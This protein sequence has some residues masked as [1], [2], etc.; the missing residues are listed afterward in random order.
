MRHRVLGRSGIRV[1]ELCLGTMTFG[2]E[3]G[4]GA[5]E[6][7]CREI[8]GAF[9]EAGG[10]F[11]DTANLYTQGSSE[12]IVGRLIAEER[13]C[14]VLATKFTLPTDGNDPNSG[15]S[16]RKSLRQSLEASLR[17]LAVDYVD[18]LWIHAWD[19]CTPMDETLRA[20]D[21][22]VSA[23]KV[24]AIGVSN[25]PAWVI[26]RSDAIA[27]LRGWSSFSALQVEY[28]L[29]ARTP[30]REL[31][32]M[33]HILGLS[34]S[35]WS[36]L[37]GGRLSGVPAGEA[38]TASTRRAGNGGLSAHEQRVVEA[39]ADIAAELGTTPARV[40]LAWVLRQ[41]LMPVLGA[42]TAGQMRDNLGACD[43][44]LGDASLETLNAVTR[45]EAGYP[46]EFLTDR[47]P[48]LAPIDRTQGR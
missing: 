21:D 1:S 37:A 3:W 4:W 13:D 8:Y 26:A 48:T 41:G 42:R 29:V 11:V 45:V 24:L 44:E 30:D 16:H 15:G 28:S 34:A 39:A 19:Q 36:P 6:A 40:A 43:V 35:A 14:V 9:R 31:L 10:N 7:E 18:L 23:G 32:P 20:L 38:P 22:V 2:T 25:T 12:K 47:C 33:A 46:H 27:E 5:A 17:R